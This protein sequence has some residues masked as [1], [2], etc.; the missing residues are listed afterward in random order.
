MSFKPLISFIIFIIISHITLTTAEKSD[1]SV[2]RPKYISELYTDYLKTEE[3][4]WQ[5]IELESETNNETIVDVI[6]AHRNVF[7]SDT[8]E[9]NSYWRSFLIFGIENLRDY[10]SNI[11]GTLVENYGFLFDGTNKIIYDPMAIEQWTRNSMFQ[12]LRE[13]SNGL[14]DTTVQRKD[15]ISQHIQTVRK[16]NKTKHFPRKKVNVTSLKLKRN[17]N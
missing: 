16:P 17:K 14:F 11:N 15:V 1:I 10:L 5:R 9:S 3:K 12:H 8:F 6:T 7:F 4:L 2:N 13:N